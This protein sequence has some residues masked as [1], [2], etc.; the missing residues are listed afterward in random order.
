MFARP[1]ETTG[2]RLR[3][4]VRGLFNEE[5]PLVHPVD[6]PLGAVAPEHP[7]EMPT[8]LGQISDRDVAELRANALQRQ[9]EAA[10][11]PYAQPMHSAPTTDLPRP[12]GDVA[13]A[14]HLTDH[15]APAVRT[16]E[17]AAESNLRDATAIVP[18]PDG[19]RG[20]R[21]GV[22]FFLAGLGALIGAI[23]YAVSLLAGDGGVANVHIKTDPPGA[24]VFLD[25]HDIGARTPLTIPSVAVG[26]RHE[27]ELRLDGFPTHKATIVAEQKNA[28]VEVAWTFPRPGE[29]TPSASPSAP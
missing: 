27:V 9:R 22:L 21:L 1:P 17:A 11:E 19:R 24:S 13:P 8:M 3:N 4:E 25:G 2:A 6:H 7:D 18:A 12:R 10:R 5:D 15:T 28:D 14:V 26:R 23:A 20:D 16:L 29:P